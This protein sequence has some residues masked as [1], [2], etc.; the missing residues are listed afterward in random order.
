MPDLEERFRSLART[1]APDLWDEIDEREPRHPLG[2]A[3]GRRIVTAAVALFVAIA[4][5]G[6]AAWAFRADQR[7]PRPGTDVI[8]GAI[9]FTSGVGGY[10]LA[11]VTLDGVVSDLTQAAG[12]E[13]DL[14][15]A[16]SPDGTK[17]AFLRYTRTKDGDDGY[18][19]ELFVTDSDAGTLVDFDQ[20]AAGFSWSPD[21]SA[22]AYSSF[23]GGSDY[24]IYTAAAD[25]TGRKAIVAT[26]ISDVEPGWSSTSDSI[27]FVSHPV[28]DHDPGDADIYV[29]RSDGS[30]LT[31]LTG[32]PG[33]ESGP[34]WSPDGTKIAYLSEE[35]DESEIF[36]M[37]ADGS[38]QVAVT[39]APTNDVADPVWSPDGTKIAFGVF[40]S[41]SW[42]V[43]VV[44]A[45]G[46]GQ[47]AVADTP[48]DETGAEWSPD[49][50]LIAY[51]AAE[52]AESCRC[53]NA[54]SFDIYVVRPD[55]TEV[56]RLTTDA[57]EIGGD[58]SWQPLQADTT[59]S[60][61][62]PTP[63]QPVT[64][65]TNVTT[66]TGI[67]EFPSGVAAGEGGVWVGAPRNDGSGAGDVVRLDPT[68]GKIVARIPTD[69]L[70]VWEFGGAGIT[71]GLGSVWVVGGTPEGERCCAALV[72][73]ID[74]ATNEVV[75]EIH[76]PDVHFGADVWADETG[77]YVLSFVEGGSELELRRL[78]PTTHTL[79]WWVPVPGQWSQTVFVS[80]GWVWVLG[81][82]PDARGPIEVDMLYRI[83]PSNGQIVEEVPLSNS[84]YAPAVASDVLWLRTTEGA[85]RFDPVTAQPV[86]EPVQPSP[87]CCS[88]A[89]VADGAG[90]VWVI[91]SRAETERTVWHIDVSG[92]IVAIG[93]V[94]DP[95]SFEQML[96]QAYAFDPVTNT[97]WVQHY[98][99][100]VSRVELLPVAEPSA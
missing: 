33:W 92:Q 78:D 75:D 6:L 51:S 82:A 23:Q 37:N 74:P 80:G 40:S 57:Q 89:F 11:T 65:E 61:P 98:E 67:A 34:V 43:F 32:S 54:G 55:G 36:V 28:R 86:G 81:T 5:I 14:A 21:G 96:G 44:N 47:M 12:G 48:D 64:V 97:I 8:N 77:L 59:S 25:G 38:G 17:I 4:G 24:D 19:Y 39:D 100:S 31:R 90:G 79:S 45:D 76:I 71:I 91:S 35:G 58:L 30:G 73:R 26:P 20:P 3:A 63:S 60:T 46:T 13:Y 93:E 42:D 56:R 15:P 70:P 50:S 2:P 83:E 9:A 53:D 69:S 49:G 87:G 41:T 85:Q 68:T 10:H 18:D 84:M 16:W 29:V 7:E 72:S 62:T 99:D 52:S 88:S 94:A 27:A 22:I 66:T 95:D 1:P